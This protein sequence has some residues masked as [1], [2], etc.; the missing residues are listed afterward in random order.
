MSED[1]HGNR[2]GSADASSS[3]YREAIERLLWCVALAYALATLA[4]LD[5]ELGRLRSQAQR[6]LRVWGVMGRQL[7]VGK[8][9]EALS[10]D[11]KQHR[12]AWQQMWQ[13]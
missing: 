5:E 12:R 1:Q 2:R 13:V 6:I 9:V 8:V 10:L 7:T 11:W 3:Q 4:L